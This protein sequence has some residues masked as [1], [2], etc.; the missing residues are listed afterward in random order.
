M[1]ERVKFIHKAQKLRERER[2]TEMVRDTD[3]IEVMPDP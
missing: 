3:L 2:Q 1:H